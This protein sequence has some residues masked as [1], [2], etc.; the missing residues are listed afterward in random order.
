M[1]KGP[2]I[3]VSV[4]VLIIAGSVVYYFYKNKEQQQLQNVSTQGQLK[5]EKV[6]F[7]Q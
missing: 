1:K 5:D 3:A 7:G 4:L 2:M 6:N